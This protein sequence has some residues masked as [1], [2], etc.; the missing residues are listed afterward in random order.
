VTGEPMTLSDEVSGCAPQVSNCH[1]RSLL[2]SLIALVALLGVSVLGAG[3]GCLAG[4]PEDVRALEVHDVSRSGR[5]RQVFT[6]VVRTIEQVSASTVESG[7]LASSFADSLTC[8]QS[9]CA[10]SEA[11]ESC[12]A[13]FDG[14]RIEVDEGLVSITTPTRRHTVALALTPS[15]LARGVTNELTRAVPPDHR[16][17]MARWSW[18]LWTEAAVRHRG[19]V[20][21][22]YVY[23][24]QLAVQSALRR[25]KSFVPG[26]VPELG[27]GGVIVREVID[28]RLEAA[29]LEPGARV[30]AIDGE[31]KQDR[32]LDQWASANPGRFVVKVEQL[33]AE[34]RFEGQRIPFRH[35]TLRWQR[36]RGVVY[37]RI[38]SFARDTLIELRRMA[39]RV[40]TQDHPGVILDLRCNSGGVLSLGLV[41]CF[42]K[43]GQT[44]ATSTAIGTAERQDHPASVEYYPWD[45]VVLVDRDSASMAEVLAASLQTHGRAVIVGE[46]TAGKAVSQTGHDIEGEGRLWLVE[47][48]FF[49]PGT[50]RTWNDT[51][52]EPDIT[53]ELSDDDRSALRELLAAPVPDLDQQLDKDPHLRRALNI[54]ADLGRQHEEPDHEI[55]NA[56]T[57]N[58]VSDEPLPR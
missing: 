12:P 5:E 13:G 42:L 32:L 31:S 8:L 9:A 17:Q 22:H 18:Y 52:I 54:L 58:P 53:I 7:A 26:F 56:G 47:R 11:P 14:L 41:D 15:R 21:D 16:R 55:G 43:P 30:R 29:G 37:V 25:G 34:R 57:R 45:L 44:V 40:G 35:R 38:D 24:D 10:E 27:G 19:E 6:E 20:H 50:D 4:C 3:R 1:M 28:P 2:V 51:G 39:R 48:L 36:W 33:G 46:G 49:Y 23:A